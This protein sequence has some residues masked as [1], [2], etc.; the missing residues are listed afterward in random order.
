M[1]ELAEIIGV[2]PSL[3]KNWKVWKPLLFGP[4]WYAKDH[5]DIICHFLITN[6]I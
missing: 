6:V 4:I 3:F 2:V 1:D 5:T